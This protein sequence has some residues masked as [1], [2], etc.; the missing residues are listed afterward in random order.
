MLLVKF[1][2]ES[3]ST[4]ISNYA[5]YVTNICKTL[6]DSGLVTEYDYDGKWGDEL[7]D[8][9]E[10]V[11]ENIWVWNIKFCDKTTCGKFSLFFEFGTYSCSTQFTVKIYSDDYIPSPTDKYLE[12]LKLTIKKEIKSDWEK[13][14]WLVDEDAATLSVSLY[15]IIY[16]VENLARQLI[17]EVMTKEYGITWWDRFV[18]I[19]I[20]EKHQNRFVVYKQSV[21]NFNN[22]DERLLTIDIADLQ[23]I[24]TYC[25]KKWKPAPDADIDRYLSE[26]TALTNERIIEKIKSNS[27]IELDLWLEHFSKYLPVD[28]LERFEDFSKD[29]NH[30]AHN[31]LL[32]RN[33]H[34]KILANAK[35]LEKDLVTALEKVDKI[36]VSKEQK[37]IIAKET[38]RLEQEALAHE[39]RIMEQEANISVRDQTE[40]IEFINEFLYE[41]YSIILDNIRFRDDIELSEFTEIEDAQ[42]SGTLFDIT[43]K[44]SQETVSVEYHID[45]LDDEP[46]SESV[47]RVGINDKF[48]DI[49][50][51]NG[52]AEFNDD[53]GCYVPITQDEILEDIDL[54]EW[55]TDYI[56]IH[57]ENLR[58]K[59]DSDMYSIIKDGGISPI[60]EFG[61][62]ECGEPYICIDDEYAPFGTCLNCG[63]HNDIVKCDRCEQYFEGE[64]NGEF[65]LCEN[66]EYD[67]ERQ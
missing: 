56:G 24:F 15:P 43:Y 22:I 59:V 32:D 5:E 11:E 1:F 16:S 55:V 26:L 36:V 40:I 54:A 57:F 48:I 23:K 62:W 4:S 28:F 3:D 20:K 21:P 47:C 67:I 51:S 50:Y 9:I 39:H 65:N 66:C 37:E 2:A 60:L 38:Y 29:R 58:E 12:Q 25:S 52:E 30:V 6:Y 13:I 33:I 19:S 44:I 14:V 8:S 7:E 17:N 31:K 27:E 46:G 10:E 63:A 49:S 35:H 64:D 41:K 18:P 34:G 61:C 53:V 42:Y 45:C